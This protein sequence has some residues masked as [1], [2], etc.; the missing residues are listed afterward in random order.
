LQYGRDGVAIALATFKIK[1]I[2]QIVNLK[3]PDLTITIEV[4]EK[5]YVYG[6]TV[7][8]PGGLPVRVAGKGVL[9]LSGGIDSPVAGFLMGKRG[10]ILDAIHFHTYPYTSKHAQEKASELA[11]H[12]SMWIGSVNLHIVP[13]TKLCVH[14]GVSAHKSKKTLLIRAA[15]MD[16]AS[17][18]A[19]FQNAVALVTGESLSQVAS[20]TAQAMRFTEHACTLPVFRPLIGMNKDEIIGIARN[21]DTYQTSILPYDDCCTV[22]SAKHPTLR[23]DF[24]E[25]EKNYKE[26]NLEP[27]IKKSLGGAETIH[28]VYGN[29]L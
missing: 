12:I 5:I 1:S 28:F 29:R 15:M 10:L 27:I 9:L 20:Q 8:S 25:T 23:P 3:Y 6:N 14:I 13:F 24:A 18:L 2:F 17:R 26:L 7:H 16:A 11:R 19:T 22:F 21:I 4:R